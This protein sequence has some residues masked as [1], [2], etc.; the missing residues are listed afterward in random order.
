M[1]IDPSQ[2][3]VQGGLRISPEK[4]T[5]T[6]TLRNGERIRAEVLSLRDD[7]T[8]EM[9]LDDGKVFSARLDSDV[10]LF[11]GD[12]MLL[13]VVGRDDGNVVL[14]IVGDESRDI[15]Y[16]ELLK[17]VRDFEDK[18]LAYMAKGLA[19]LNLPVNESTA[20][21]MREILQQNPGMKLEEAA[22]L[23]SNKL[24]GDENLTK[25]ALS[26]LADGAKTDAIIERLLNML[27]SSETVSDAAE[28]QYS[29]DLTQQSENANSAPLTDLMTHI[30]K[31]TMNNGVIITHNDTD[32]QSTNA[33]KNAN[34]LQN[35]IINDDSLEIADKTP[36]ITDVS[37]EKSGISGGS[38]AE[39]NMIKPSDERAPASLPAQ[40]EHIPS[41]RSDNTSFIPNNA[42]VESNIESNIK[43]NPA[44]DSFSPLN[45]EN[46]QIAKTIANA[47]S[48]LPEFRDSPPEAVTKFSNMLVRVAEESKHIA[49]GD[50]DKL[51][52]LLESLFTRI[53][54]FDENAGDRLRTA[55][56]EL[57]ARLAFIEEAI[58]KASPPAKAEMLEQTR[59]LMDHVRL[60]N[61]IGQFTYMQFPVR[62]G[63]E[64]KTAELYLF[65][66]K[67]G[68]K[69]DPENVNILLAIDLE[70]M[71]RW[72]ALVNIRKKDVSIQMEVAGEQE[73]EFFSDNTV[74]LY[75]MLAEAGFKL[76]STSISFSEAET[77]PLTALKTLNRYTAGRAGHIDFRI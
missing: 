17:L 13:E 48:E 52:N 42:N 51:K 8:V 7:N 32:L 62:I 10:T 58:S 38:P 14:S 71:G 12:K 39:E 53:E 69:P 43:S 46:S 36:L 5:F 65:K 11:P 76:T 57:F 60:L 1:K 27:V 77:T 74:L 6:D 26:L 22:F 49:G 37:D 33:I 30:E 67:G 15:P 31:S 72:E 40:N 50:T 24:F 34:I 47:I 18:S 41:A 3:L 4:G 75:N 66:R 35:S 55:K 61:N 44:P 19:D 21:M 56:E 64:N 16:N 59:G 54:R 73:K 68:R 25:A 45:N 29:Q 63:D 2:I 9:K 23:A 28:T 20:K 70:N